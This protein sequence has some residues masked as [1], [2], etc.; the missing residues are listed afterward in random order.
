MLQISKQTQKF[1]LKEYRKK[2]RHY[3]D[4]AHICH[5][6]DTLHDHKDKFSDFQAAE[7]AAN[8]HD[9]VYE[10]GDDYDYNEQR[11][12]VK[13]LEMIEEDNPDL[14]YDRNDPDFRTVELALIMI[15][16]THGHTLDRIRDPE[17]L[18]SGQLEDIKM[19]LDADIKILAENEDKVLRFEDEIRKEFSIYSDE[20]YSQG[21]IRVLQSFLNRRFLYLSEIGRPWEQKAR[22]NLQFLIDRLKYKKS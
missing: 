20:V 6:L 10:V 13:F 7:L 15:G 9:I 22:N 3:H 4:Y 17:S 11:S 1:L 16:C 12:C 8:F 14:K 18:T 2:H 5:V 21:R 19:F